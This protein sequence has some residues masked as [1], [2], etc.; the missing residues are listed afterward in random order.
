VGYVL[1]PAYYQREIYSPY[2]YMGEKLGGNARGVASA[3]FTLGGMLAQSARVY[4]TAIVLTVVLADQLDW[5]SNTL[6][7]TPLAWAIILITVVAVAWSVIGGITTVIWTDVMLFLL[8]LVG[9]VI[10]LITVAANVEGGFGAMISAGWQARYDGLDAGAA[11]SWWNWGK[12]TFFDFTSSLPEVFTSPYTIWAGIIA[13][14]WGSLGP[15]GTDQLIVQRMFCCKNEK[16]ARWAMISSTLS[17]IVTSIVMLVGLGLF[18][19]YNQPL[20]G[21]V[22]GVAQHPQ[23]PR[24][25]GEALD[26][27]NREPNRIFPIF[28]VDVIPWGLKGILIAGIFAAAISSL[29]S[30]LA[31]LSQTSISAFYLPLR[32]QAEHDTAVSD[33]EQKHRVMVSRILIVFW[34]IVLALMAYVAKAMTAQFP[35][36]LNLALAMAGF[37]GGGLLAGF[38]LGFLRLGVDHWGFQFSAP[39]SVLYVFAIVFHSDWAVWT[40]VVAGVLLLVLWVVTYLLDP[41]GRPIIPRPLQFL[42]LTVGAAG[43][44]LVAKYGYFDSATA[45]D[46]NISYT[47]LAWPW[48]VPAGSLVAFIWGFMLARHEKPDQGVPSTT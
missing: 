13:A 8:F 39:L 47:I 32:G 31:A 33:A 40:C 48:Y 5:L 9:A 28:I 29:T 18:V 41:N 15:Y 7:A 3:L 14:T 22:E 1:V 11:P 23:F 21:A 24:L 45:P 25:T 16:S 20:D 38:F 34:G 6:G 19:Y 17:Q 42:L 2:D 44:I 35:E 37:A 26:L 10:A 27:F 36:L 12:F 46:G 43:M 4:L 30:I